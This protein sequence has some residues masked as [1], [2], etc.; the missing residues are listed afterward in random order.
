LLYKTLIQTDISLFFGG[1]TVVEDEETGEKEDR[2]L[3]KLSDAL[4]ASY[5]LSPA[6][7]LRGG[8]TAGI[9]AYSEG[10]ING[11]MNVGLLLGVH[12]LPES[13]FSFT[14]DIQPGYA[15]TFHY[16]TA[17][18]DFLGAFSMGSQDWAFP[19]VLGVRLN[20]DKF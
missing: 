20:F 3:L 8:L 6:L 13:L 5:P 12:I 19:V 1:M 18:S 11:F 15:F 10:L 7:S 14:F 9:G 17:N 2:L 16:D 4:F